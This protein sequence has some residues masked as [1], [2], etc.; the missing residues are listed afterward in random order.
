MV[1][2]LAGQPR[3][4]KEINKDLIKQVIK[5]K[6]PISKPEIARIT[7]LSL[8]TVNK[9]VDHLV[10]TNYVK[11]NGLGDTGSGRKPVLYEINSSAGN[12]IALFFEN[13]YIKGAVSNI[14]GEILE[15]Q[16]VEI[17]LG[18]KEEALNSTCSIIDRL[19][20]GRENVKAIGIGVPGVVKPQGT[21]YSIPNIT[22][23]EGINLKKIIQE[24]YRIPVFIENDVNLI[25]LGVYYRQLK[26]KYSNVVYV[27]FGKGIGSGI[28]IDK[29]LYKGSTNFAG[30]ISYMVTQDLYPEQLY[31][32]RFKGLLEKEVSD[33]IKHI[34]RAE[35]INSYNELKHKMA[36]EEAA[37]ETVGKL[38]RKV[39]FTLINITCVLNPEAIVVKG[40]FIYPEFIEK[41][42]KIIDNYLPMDIPKILILEDEDAGLIGTINLCI[43][44][45]SSNYLL[46]DNT[47]E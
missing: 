42:K 15:T 44:N 41:V 28:I 9:I 31:E 10:E 37:A 29:K 8:P 12:V 4:I 6:G 45:I 47:G 17:D 21:I 46:L 30:E 2:K 34:C 36:D 16:R 23:W 24:R 38:I 39:A 3:L 26:K 25:A 18:S 32:A 13:D 40:N 35:S 27:Y 20:Q 43:S 14:I 33:I 11:A 1:K 19:M 5:D 7:K 22:G